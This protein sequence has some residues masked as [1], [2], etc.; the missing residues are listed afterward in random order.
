MKKG[1]KCKRI[2]RKI[3]SFF[4]ISA[5]GVV[6]TLQGFC[7]STLNYPLDL[8]I[9][10]YSSW[11]N[12]SDYMQGDDRW[13]KFQ[14]L[15]STRLFDCRYTLADDVNDLFSDLESDTSYSLYI[16]TAWTIQNT[17]YNTISPDTFASK[18]Y[19][20]VTMRNGS[21]VR[22]T[23]TVSYTRWT[24][25]TGFN[26][27]YSYQIPEGAK[28]IYQVNFGCN[29]NSSVPTS[30]PMYL[31]V[32]PL[33]LTSQ[34]GTDRV[35]SYLDQPVTPP[36]NQGGTDTTISDYQQK[37]D[38]LTSQAAGVI[39]DLPGMISALDMS[40]F[41]GGFNLFNDLFTDFW[42]RSGKLKMIALFAIVSGSVMVILG[43]AVRGSRRLD[44][45]KPPKEV[46]HKHYLAGKSKDNSSNK[47]SD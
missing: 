28:K 17:T 40:D 26:A 37:E 1:K 10:L 12:V 45:D 41:A 32:Y 36:A 43:L 39:S 11:N 22:V 5:F 38:Q 3:V 15:S 16:K 8:S 19:L 20:M 35:V 29:F 33:Q 14:P 30:I 9:D 4:L 18:S 44:P 13:G 27:Y 7:A 24:G 46:I 21:S 23:P 34:S 6:F 25:G 31:T 42:S 47:G 2:F